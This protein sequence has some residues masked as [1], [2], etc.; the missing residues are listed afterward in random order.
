MWEPNCG[1]KHHVYWTVYHVQKSGWIIQ[2]KNR[3]CSVW[4]VIKWHKKHEM[5]KDW[6]CQK[7][8]IAYRVFEYYNWDTMFHWMRM[9]LSYS[10]RITIIRVRTQ[11]AY[12]TFFLSLVFSS[13]IHNIETWI[14]CKVA[15]IKKIEHLHLLFEK[16]LEAEITSC[17]LSKQ[18]QPMNRY[19]S[20]SATEKTQQ[21]K[22]LCPIW[23]NNKDL[24][25][26]ILYL[27]FKAKPKQYCCENL[28][29]SNCLLFMWAVTVFGLCKM[30]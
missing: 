27:K 8:D 11:F 4:K 25:I 24:E 5:W 19:S 17:F 30:E 3:A 21:L 29:C 14:C 6:L 12:V 28:K 23:V 26:L 22:S 9:V 15:T 18:W 2:C 7:A 16:D 10:G 13:S 1:K 20:D